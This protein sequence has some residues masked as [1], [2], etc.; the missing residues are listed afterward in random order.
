MDSGADM[1]D[2]LDN[3]TVLDEFEDYLPEEEYPIFVITILNGF[4]TES[5]I[6]SILDNI[7]KKKA[8]NVSN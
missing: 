2:I 4:K 3:T 1:D 6:K 7:E 5:I 8:L